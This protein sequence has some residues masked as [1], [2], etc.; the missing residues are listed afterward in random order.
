M[1]DEIPKK[2]RHTKEVEAESIAYVVCQHFGIDT[3][4]YSFPY[5]TGWSRDKE[6]PELKASLECISKTAAEMIDSVEKHCS[7]KEKVSVEEQKLE[8]ILKPNF[9][10]V[11]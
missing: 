9:S 7:E 11:K 6:L 10:C 3:S 2:D 5:V 8:D 1:D 4:D